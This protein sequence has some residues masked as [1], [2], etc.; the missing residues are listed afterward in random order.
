MKIIYKLLIEY[1]NKNIYELIF[2][3]YEA[4]EDYIEEAKDIK[5][6]EITT[7]AKCE[8]CNQYDNVSYYSIIKRESFT[9]AYCLDCT[10]NYTIN[11]FNYIEKMEP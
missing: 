6:F 10:P 4:I 2:D 7:L 11:K 9:N 8:G 5:W 1:K 3:N